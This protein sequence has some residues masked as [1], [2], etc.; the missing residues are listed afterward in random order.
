M[1]RGGEKE[2]FNIQHS[3]P[4]IEGTEALSTLNVFGKDKKRDL[5]TAVS[6]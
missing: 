3:T 4:N 6:R 1:S 2:T 5:F